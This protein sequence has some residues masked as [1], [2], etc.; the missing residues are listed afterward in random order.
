MVETIEE[1]GID[2]ARPEGK[3]GVERK[4]PFLRTRRQLED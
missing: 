2:R 3:V 4:G 1:E